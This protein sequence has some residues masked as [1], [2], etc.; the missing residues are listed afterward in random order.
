M[1]HLGWF[2]YE[3]VQGWGSAEFDTD[4]G[5]AD[6][7]LHQDMARR[8]EQACLDFIL[9]EDLSAIPDTYGESREVYLREAV[10]APKFD[11][12]VVAGLMAAATSRIGAFARAA[13][14]AAL[15]EFA[16]AVRSETVPSR[17]VG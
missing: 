8:L 13:M 6:P 5:W 4:Y 9:L 12:A 10:H 2:L 14:K 15:H 16:N 11:P 17:S 1:F 3:A 7:R